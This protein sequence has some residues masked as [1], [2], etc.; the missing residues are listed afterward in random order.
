MNMPIRTATFSVDDYLA[1]E[2][3]AER[4][5]EYIAGRVYEMPGGTNNHNLIANNITSLLHTALRGKK[6]RVFNSDTKIRI[7]TE[8]ETRFYY[9]DG[10]VV[11]EMNSGQETFQSKPALV[12]EVL[13]RSTRRLDEGEKRDAYLKLP[14]LQM[15]ILLE[16]ETAFARVDRR[17]ESTFVAEEYAGMEA[18]ISLPFLE[19]QLCLAEIYE[20]VEFVVEGPA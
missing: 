7:Q 16:Q 5:R 11:C 13:S 15:L 19:T 12:V 14:S 2:K 3:V 6:C 9:S 18:I 8:L 4:K 20:Q 10:Q 17:Q 1:T